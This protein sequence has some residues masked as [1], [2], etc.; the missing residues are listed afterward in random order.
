MLI[1]SVVT[2]GSC[3]FF[4]MI[5]E[6]AVVNALYRGERPTFPSHIPFKAI[7]DPLVNEDN[8]F[9][10]LCWSDNPKDR[11]NLS[12][13]EVLLKYLRTLILLIEYFFFSIII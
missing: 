11:P 9:A 4:N 8:G 6:E 1:F 7:L 13:L 5:W 10:T 12:S 3:P 2:D